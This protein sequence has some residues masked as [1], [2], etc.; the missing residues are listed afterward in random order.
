ML[1][2]S[3]V[4]HYC[5]FKKIEKTRILGILGICHP[6]GTDC[7]LKF[8][9]PIRAGEKPEL[10]PKTRLKK[11][12]YLKIKKSLKKEKKK[13]FNQFFFFPKLQKKVGK[14]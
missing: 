1:P 4:I 10:S 13:T 14:H 7:K 11:G 3:H 8:L 9:F 2:P 12:S 5:G 6:C